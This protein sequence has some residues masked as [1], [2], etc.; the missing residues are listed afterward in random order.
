MSHVSEPAANGLALEGRVALVTGAASGIGRAVA[1]RFAAA[2]AR[3]ACVDLDL[4]RAGET[5]RLISPGRAVAQ[6]LDVANGD[7][8]LAVAETIQRLGDL[9]IL[10]NSAGVGLERRFLETSRTEWDRVLAVN[11]TGTFMLSQAVARAMALRGT[12]GGRI[13]NIASVNGLRGSTGR[14]AYGASKGGVVVLTKVMAVELAPLGVTVNAV[15]PGPIDT[16]L[17]RAMHSPATRAAWRATIPMARYG[18]VADVAEA[19]LFLASP[20]AGYITGTV[21]AVDGGWTG[22]GLV[23]E[24]G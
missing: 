11:L 24:P 3:V 17:A 12:T 4:E 1:L 20:G 18:D 15:A 14:A 5:A 19:V 8:E 9:H 2:G 6:H 7:A 13:V 22:A 23:F 21:L 10:V 16:P